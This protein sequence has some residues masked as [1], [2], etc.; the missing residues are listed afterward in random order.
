MCDIAMCTKKDCPS[1]HKC[2]RAQDIKDTHF[3]WYMKFDNLLSDKCN[4]YIKKTK[5]GDLN[6]K[7]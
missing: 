7:I 2:R 6:A 3:Q 1:F 5:T 4:F